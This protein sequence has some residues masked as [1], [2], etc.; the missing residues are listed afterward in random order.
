MSGARACLGHAS[1]RS[2]L[3]C[4]T[5]RSPWRG[6]GALQRGGLCR[7]FT[8]H[9]RSP[10]SRAFLPRS[11]APLIALAPNPPS[12]PFTSSC[13]SRPRPRFQS[14]R[15][16][17][18]ASL[19]LSSSAYPPHPWD[20]RSSFRPQPCRARLRWINTT[21][22]ASEKHRSSTLQG[23]SAKSRLLPSSGPDA[24]RQN[25]RKSAP[26]NGVPNKSQDHRVYAEISAVCIWKEVKEGHPKDGPDDGTCGAKT[27]AR[28]TP[29]TT[30]EHRKVYEPGEYESHSSPCQSARPHLGAVPLNFWSIR[31]KSP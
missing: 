3:R 4:H 14:I 5:A 30:N 12:A 13:S 19:P 15:L 27:A 11:P 16:N 17:E 25:R 24:D 22:L 2:A 28:A 1:A 21:G 10:S 23:L 29:Q 20:L 31:S 6:S 9:P 18:I 26:H 7:R 8:L